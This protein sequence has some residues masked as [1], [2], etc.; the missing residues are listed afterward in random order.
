MTVFS[1]HLPD[2]DPLN[3]ALFDRVNPCSEN[4]LRPEPLPGRHV[5]RLDI[6]IRAFVVRHNVS[7]ALMNN[8][9]D[10]QCWDSLRECER[11]KH[12]HAH[13]KSCNKSAHGDEA[14]NRYW[15]SY[16]T[17]HNRGCDASPLEIRQLEAGRN[18]G[19]RGLMSFVG[20]MLRNESIVASSGW[21]FQDGELWWRWSEGVALG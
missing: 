19:S 10:F 20:F 13:E 9:F 12:Q 16:L 8:R 14:S 21:P 5:P 18:F 4:R 11:R 7:D 17:H 1:V 3:A 2:E 6:R 15:V